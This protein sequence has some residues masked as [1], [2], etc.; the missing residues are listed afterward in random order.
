MAAPCWQRRAAA[1][2]ASPQFSSTVALTFSSATPGS[3]SGAGRER[4][5][6][7]SG[8]GQRRAEG[9]HEDR[10]RGNPGTKFDTSALPRCRA[11]DE[12]IANLS[13]RACPRSSKIGTVKGQGLIVTGNPFNTIAT[14]FNGRR[15][16]IV[17]VRLVDD[18]RLITYFRDD[19][20]GGS[21]A[22]NLKIP[23]GVALTR[24]EAHVPRHYR[25]YKGKRRAYLRTP[26]TCPPSGVWTTTAI[27]TY[28]D[29]SSQQRATT[30]PCKA[31]LGLSR[32]AASWSRGRRAAARARARARG[33]R[34]RAPTGTPLPVRDGA[35]PRAPARGLELDHAGRVRA[36]PTRC[37]SGASAPAHAHLAEPAAEARLG[38]D[39][40]PQLGR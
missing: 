8:R 21:V 29:G 23:G 9:G 26:P 16:I 35:H 1:A 10:V 6:E 18:G 34:R 14:L 3:P 27:F 2:I 20:R 36:R 13:V 19:V 17:V 39:L 25:R 37:G 7:R 38:A 31:G 12:D 28:R 24:F 11:S 30:T 4:R 40:V 15:Q 32:S 5:V 33:A 22:V